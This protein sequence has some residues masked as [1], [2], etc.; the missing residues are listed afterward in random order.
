VFTWTSGNVY[1]GNYFEDLRH[2]YGEMVWIDNSYYKGTW[3]VSR[4]KSSSKL[5]NFKSFISDFF[6]GY[7]STQRGIQHGEGEMCMSGEY[8]KQGLFENNI[9]MGKINK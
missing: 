2:G 7:S 5:I 8:P 1:K 3:E 6:L 4:E 9:Y